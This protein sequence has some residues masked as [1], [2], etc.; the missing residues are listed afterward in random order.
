ML[1]MNVRRVKHFHGALFGFT[2]IELLVV[3]AIIAILAA[4]LLPALA[5]AKMK[6]QRIQCL[7]NEKEMGLGSQLYA[8][9]DPL[10]ALAGTYNYADDDLN[11]LYPTYIPNINV[12]ICPGTQDIITPTEVP[13]GN[14]T[15]EPYDW[16]LAGQPT[17][18]SYQNRLHGNDQ[19]VLDL[20]HIA[21]DDAS[22]PTLGLTYNIQQKSGHGTSYEVSGFFDQIT[23]KTQNNVVAY[24]YPG[25]PIY[26]LNGK[27]LTYAIKGQ[28]A[29]SSDIW[30]MYD[31]IDPMTVAGYAHQSND[32]YPD[33]VDNH[34]HDGINVVFSDGHASWVANNVN[35]P[36][37]FALGTGETTGYTWYDP[38]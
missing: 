38:F 8:D 34:G 22:Y 2:L 23:I 1:L 26:S 24:N 6:A 4:L 30:L 21:Q 35:Y 13:I 3:I 33:W 20:Q 15:T 12:F 5:R 19:I 32:N 16:T 17:P 27:N 28:L 9:E 29:S 18:P 25:N 14:L 7:N 11:W 36:Y 10:G 31:G 37:I